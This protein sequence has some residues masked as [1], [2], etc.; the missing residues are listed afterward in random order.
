[1]SCAA[2]HE[3]PAAARAQAG[4]D[5]PGLDLLTTAITQNG[6][7]D[8]WTDAGETAQE[9][10]RL[11]LAARETNPTPA[12]DAALSTTD[13][14]LAWRSLREYGSVANQGP[15]DLAAMWSDA[16][17]A[18][19]ESVAT[20][21]VVSLGHHPQTDEVLL[22]LLFRTG[23]SERAA[24]QLGASLRCWPDHPALH[25]IVRSWR[26]VIPDPAALIAQLKA[27]PV[28]PATQ[29]RGDTQQNWASQGYLS[30]A[31]ALRFEQAGDA[32][33]AAAVYEA[34]AVAFAGAAVPLQLMD[35]PAHVLDEWELLSR[36][37]DCLVNAGWLRFA[38]AQR[39]IGAEDLGAAL[40]A[41]EL[42]EADFVGALL[43]V[44]ED[45]DATEGIGLTGDLY[46]QAGSPDG[47]RDFF[48]RVA[49]QFE[50]PEWWN[51]YAFFCRETGEYEASYAAY[52][53][54]IELA[55]DNARWVNDTGLI[56]LYHLDRD[57]DYAEEL[58]R[59]SWALGRKACENPFVS[60]EAYED[61]FLGYTDAMHNLAL[62]L[63]RRDD[64]QQALEVNAELL[65][66]AP[67]RPDAIQV[68]L[69]L[70]RALA[71]RAESGQAGSS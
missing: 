62:L 53:R 1:M 24:R 63:A 31:L 52:Q 16:N 38:E 70:E 19:A 23:Q 51:N 54:C 46:Y 22:D 28:G 36:R 50:N 60:D 6:Q 41:L 55:P 29:I 27:R 12:L 67:G 14:L 69:Q 4:L 61:A 8:L 40:P 18:L 10:R 59:R 57:L 47:I 30:L 66:L 17:A 49:P 37:A 44:P 65:E 34:G 21:L 13:A 20:M 35:R 26:D 45:A 3:R 48:G 64:L 33:E 7:P 56:L 9:A 32:T 68:K 11:M 5:L 25:A 71:E 2:P 58:F 15:V 39:A 43:A 42:A